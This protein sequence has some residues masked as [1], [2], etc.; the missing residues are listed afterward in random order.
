[1]TARARAAVVQYRGSPY[2]IGYFSDNEIGWWNGSLFHV[3]KP[4]TRPLIEPSNASMPCCALTTPLTGQPSNVTSS[5]RP[6]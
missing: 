5:H 3:F 1:M 2:R 6:A 4:G